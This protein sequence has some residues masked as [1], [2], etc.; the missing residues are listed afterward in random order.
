M[1]YG[2]MVQISLASN[3]P[4]GHAIHVQLHRL[5]TYCRRI[6]VH[7]GLECITLAAGATPQ[8]L[9]TST[10]QAILDVIAMMTT[11]RTRRHGPKIPLSP[12]W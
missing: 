3:A 6:P 2:V 10:G 7:F 8:A 9:T 1:D 11:W 5:G 12:L 4:E